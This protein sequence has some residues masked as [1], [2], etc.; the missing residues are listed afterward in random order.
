MKTANRTTRYTS[1]AIWTMKSCS[2][3]ALSGFPAFPAPTSALCRRTFI[4]RVAIS[5]YLVAHRDLSQNLVN[6]IQATANPIRIPLTP[7]FNLHFVA[8]IIW[9]QQI[10]PLSFQ[11][12]IA[13]IPLFLYLRVTGRTGKL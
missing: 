5:W 8:S 1:C 2:L 3:S 9:M 13:R 10:M 7:Q 6:D 4:A 11:T 12:F